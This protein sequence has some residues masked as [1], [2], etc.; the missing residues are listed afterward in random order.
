[1][2][3]FAIYIPRFT[4]LFL[5][6]ISLFDLPSTSSFS[7]PDSN[8]NDWVVS[9]AKAQQEETSRSIK[10]FPI[11]RRSNIAF[12]LTSCSSLLFLGGAFPVE[13]AFEDGSCQTDCMYKCQQR[14]L[15]DSKVTKIDTKYRASMTLNECQE[16]CQDDLKECR[17]PPPERKREPRLMQAA[18]IKGLYP[19]WQDSF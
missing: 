14:E 2:T 7:L 16:Q 17:N 12:M 15:Q 19:R 3:T 6:W 4:L 18:D 11:S 8:S 10:A 5:F 9:S 13:A 1:M